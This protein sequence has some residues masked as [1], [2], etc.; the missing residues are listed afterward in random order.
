M[1][2]FLDRVRDTHA[3]ARLEVEQ[4]PSLKLL[5]H[6]HNMRVVRRLV[7]HRKN[8]AVKVPFVVARVALTL[9]PQS[10]TGAN[11]FD[12]RRSVFGIRSG[13]GE[14]SGSGKA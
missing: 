9:H 13:G 4:K 10:C 1:S 3:L 8:G 14:E 11:N 6:S 2:N 12:E 7:R 5:S